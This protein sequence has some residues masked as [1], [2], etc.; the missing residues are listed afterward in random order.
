M[1]SRTASSKS[2]LAKRTKSASAAI[3]INLVFVLAGAVGMMYV[4]SPSMFRSAA[5]QPVAKVSAIP[6]KKAPPSLPRS[7]PM[8]LTAPDISLD[9]ELV[10]TGKNEQGELAVP[11]RH[12]VAA[13]YELSPTPGEIGPSVI[14]GHV[15]TY[16]GPSVF[17][18][19]KDLKPGQFV[20]VDRA[21]GSRVKFRVDRS[22]LVDQDAFPTQE[23]YGNIDHAGLRLIT[24]GGAFNPAK[25]EYLQNTVVF[26]TYVPE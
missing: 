1:P 3:V 22:E 24:C 23:V 9:T 15:D 26:A 12:D 25:G 6:E 5:Q 20:Y 11:E 17:F 14:V 18:Y 13:W 2:S 7:L 19:L 16:L 4:I 8:R 10:T 21:D